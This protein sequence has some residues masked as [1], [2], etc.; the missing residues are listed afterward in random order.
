MPDPVIPASDVVRYVFGFTNAAAAAYDP[1]VGTYRYAEVLIFFGVSGPPP[2]SSVPVQGYNPMI[3]Q[4]GPII[5]ALYDH[6]NL[7][8]A[9]DLALPF[10]GQSAILKTVYTA[11]QMQVMQLVLDNY[12]TIV[13]SGL[14]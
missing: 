3:T 4:P 10:R 8:M 2:N 12:G 14:N 13:A 5:D 11:A 7:L 6:P 1:V 9:L